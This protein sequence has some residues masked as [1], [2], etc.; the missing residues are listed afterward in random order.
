MSHQHTS[1]AKDEGQCAKFGR[2][3]AFMSQEGPV[4]YKEEV[5]EE[6]GFGTNLLLVGYDHGSK[7]LWVMATDRKGVTGSSLKLLES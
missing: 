5:K 4:G 1:S 2:G 6:F 3:Y 7:S